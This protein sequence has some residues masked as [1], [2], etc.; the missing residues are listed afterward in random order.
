METFLLV[1][2]VRSIYNIGSLFRLA[3]AVGLSKLYLTGFTP[4]PKKTDDDRPAYVATKT[5]QAIKKTALEG[6]G[7]VA[8]E[9][10]PNAVDVCQ[11]LKGDGV[12][13]VGIEQTSTSLNYLD[14]LKSD[15]FLESQAVCF[16]VGHE[17]GGVDQ[18]VLDLCDKVIEIPMLGKGKSLNVAMSATVVLYSAKIFTK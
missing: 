17:T 16:I 10:H 15:H 14:Y 5:D 4:Y 11:K 8:W 7:N 1:N 6:L 9:Y 2:N 18:D 12:L 3:D 13:L